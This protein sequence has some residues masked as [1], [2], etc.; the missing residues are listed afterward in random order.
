MPDTIRAHKVKLRPNRYQVAELEDRG[1][2]RNGAWNFYL[3]L[4]EELYAW[5]CKAVPQRVRVW[6]PKKRE[7][8]WRKT[9]KAERDAAPPVGVAS[10]EPGKPPTILPGRQ[11]A[12]G[13]ALGPQGV[14]SAVFRPYRDSGTPR[15]WMT[16]LTQTIQAAF[17]DAGR[18]RDA[19]FAGGGYPR[20]KRH[21][22]ERKA[23]S[24][25]PSVTFGYRACAATLPDST[26]VRVPT[27]RGSDAAVLDIRTLEDLTWLR[28]AID[29]GAKLCAVRITRN[30][31]GRWHAV[32]QVNYGP[33]PELPNPEAVTRDRT[34]G[35]DWG[36]K[37]TA[38]TDR[39]QYFIA[40]APTQ[41]EAKLE[42]AQ[43][44]QA[45]HRKGSRRWRKLAQRIRRIHEKI[46][47]VRHNHLHQT[48][49]AIAQGSDVDA[50]AIEDLN[51]SGMSRSARGTV[52]EPGT[53]VAAKAGL[54]RR[55]LAAAPGEFRRMFE[56]KCAERGKHLV[57]VNP[58][59]TSRHC[60][61]CGHT[62]PANRPTQALFLCEQCGHTNNAD[63]NAATN[64][65]DLGIASLKGGA[66]Q[67]QPAGKPARKARQVRETA[68]R[69]N[70][71][72]N[73]RKGSHGGETPPP[74][75]Q[76]GDHWDKKARNPGEPSRR[77]PRAVGTSANR[78]G[79]AKGAA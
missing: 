51:V 64:I 46:G 5:V 35:V 23:Y 41:L 22:R 34:L 24:T 43:R 12:K 61:A 71:A 29:A 50:V 73:S 60:P 28:N 48:T 47:A 75:T 9:T 32:L 74:G 78:R 16:T 30:T 38:V 27:T 55:I 31:H 36:V 67:V 54:N 8:V 25:P 13:Y 72:G 4:Q 63:A 33:A 44:A 15:P 56:Y 79:N 57:A 62:D 20:F 1:R 69:S 37:H 77:S 49:T 26:H 39:G 14:Y 21:P 66:R 6:D 3:G 17:D 19:F 18:A 11:A 58:R 65:G 40:P 52:E 70:G 10:D 2:A 59:N 76:R 42:S 7:I 53:N 68:S 45:R